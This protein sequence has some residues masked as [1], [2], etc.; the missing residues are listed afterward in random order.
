MSVGSLVADNNMI[1]G[2]G[3]MWLWIKQREW[4]DILQ[5]NCESLLA[6]IHEIKLRPVQQCPDLVLIEET[7]FSSEKMLKSKATL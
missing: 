4:I 1:D 6:N 2:S 3:H 7:N 5:Y